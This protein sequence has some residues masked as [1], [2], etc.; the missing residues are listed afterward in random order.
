VEEAASE[1]SVTKK[2][3]RYMMARNRMVSLSGF[4]FSAVI[5]EVIEFEVFRV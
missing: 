1:V 5:G 4:V 3:L 2:W